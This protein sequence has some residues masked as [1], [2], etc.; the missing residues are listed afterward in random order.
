MS[1][2][3]AYNL[4]LGQVVPEDAA[5]VPGGDQRLTAGQPLE[6]GG[7]TVVAPDALGFAGLN[8]D[9][10]HSAVHAGDMAQ[11]VVVRE[12]KA[13]RRRGKPDFLSLLSQHFGMFI[14]LGHG[15]GK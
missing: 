15:S 3:V 14:F 2:D 6:R 4:A 5:I 13:I 9:F 7:V 10:V 1:L 12:G 11:V 8:L